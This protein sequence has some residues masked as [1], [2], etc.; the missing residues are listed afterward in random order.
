MLVSLYTV[1]VVL[2]VLGVEDYGIYNVVGGIVT[3]FTFLSGTMASATQRFFSFAIGEK[4]KDKL[5]KTFSMNVILYVGIVFIAALLL[6][7][8]GLWFVQN[9]LQ[10]PLDRLDVV[11]GV[12][13]FSV[14]T[15][16][17]SILAAPFMAIII[18]HEDMQYYAYISIV[19]AFM[20]LS[21]VF[22]LTTISYDKLQLYAMLLA[23]V[24]AVN[25]LMY[26]SVCMKKYSECQLKI[27]HWDKTQFKEILDFTGWTLFGQITT[28]SRNQ[29]ITILLNQ[30][31]SPVTVAARAIATQV[32]SKINMFA[33]NFNVGLYP[34][35]IKAYA[36]EEKEDMYKLICNGSKITFFLMWVI[37]LPIFIELEM[38]FSIWLKEVPIEAFLFTRLALIESLI[39]SVSM[40]IATAARAPG[41]MKTYELTLGLLQFALFFIAWF[42]ISLSAPAYAVYIVAIGINFVMFFVRLNIVS[43]LTG[44]PIARFIK[45]TILPLLLIVTLSSAIIYSLRAMLLHSLVSSFVVGCLSVVVS[46]ILMFYIGLTKEWQTKIKQKALSK[47]KFK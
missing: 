9:K 3:M 22:L 4:N 28:V 23:A 43:N 41:R 19:E 29:A 40:P 39:L 13:H 37:A 27:F 33:N 31:F 36:A 17:C 32:T 30:A 15:F 24:S 35:I 10:V 12:F 34:P 7:T 44:L 6:E 45:Q 25:M 8:V 20:K 42:V 16:I 1:R 21:T 38:I 46:C 18:A 26:F 47:I 14:I 2:D 5:N 11:I